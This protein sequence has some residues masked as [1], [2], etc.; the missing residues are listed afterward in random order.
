MSNNI[1]FAGRKQAAITGERLKELNLPYTRMI[2]ST[3]SRATETANIIK[4]S[5]PCVP[6]EDCSMLEEGAPIPPEP[7]IGYWKPEVYV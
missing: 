2:R 1:I 5:I 7:P 3:M 6:V 4:N